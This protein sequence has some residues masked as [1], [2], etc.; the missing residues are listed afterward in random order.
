MWRRIVAGWVLIGCTAVLGQTHQHGTMP[1]GDGQYNPFV[2]ADG[3][4]GFYLVYVERSNNVSNVMLR[5][6]SDGQRFSAPIRVNNRDGDATVR[7]E[8]PPK[9]AVAPNGEVYVCWANE[10]E[11]WKGNVRFAR[12]TDGGKTFSPAITLNSD[13]AG[14]PTGHAFQSVAV[15]GKGRIYAAWID[16]RNKQKEDRGAEIWLS[17]SE[18]GGKTFSHDRRVLSDVCECCRTGLQ[19]DGDGSIF[20]SYRLVP[21]TG[22]MYR[23]IVVARSLDGGRSF[24]PA[25]VSLDGWEIDGCPVAGPSF[26]LDGVGNLTVIWFTGGGERPGLYYATSNNHGGSFS[27]RR[28]LDPDQRIG[29]HATLTSIPGGKTFVVWDDSASQLVTRWGVLDPRQGTLTRLGQKEGVSY[30]VTASGH[31]VVVLAAT[32]HAGRSIFTQREHLP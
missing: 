14:E 8:N 5:H 30:P 25:V 16:E 23:N 2:T 7:N 13:A 24:V 17:T 20:L 6:S 31:K 9:V 3:R 4:G 28:M 19:V 29:K 21:R 27:P 10:R 1:A 22:P 12:S 15:D 11:R 18:D 26:S 32:E